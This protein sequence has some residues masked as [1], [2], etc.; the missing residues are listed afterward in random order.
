MSSAHYTL[1]NKP[2]HL[3]QSYKLCRTISLTYVANLPFREAPTRLVCPTNMAL[4][5]QPDILVR[6]NNSIS[7]GRAISE[8]EHA[9]I[10]GVNELELSYR[11]R[12]AVSNH[13]SA[14]SPFLESF[15]RYKFRRWYGLEE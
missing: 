9:D 14:L 12:R 8:S 5:E 15:H 11:D 10:E 6:P 2:G 13:S 3:D 7:S 1:R 4:L